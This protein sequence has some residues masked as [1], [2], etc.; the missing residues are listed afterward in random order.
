MRDAALAEKKDPPT[1]NR[2]LKL[3]HS[4]ERQSSV[5][6]RIVTLFPVM[7]WGTAV[8]DASHE[9]SI[10]DSCK[11]YRLPSRLDNGSLRR[12]FRMYVIVD[13]TTNALSV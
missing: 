13:A 7:E 5:G 3:L 2:T 11:N 8:Q 12:A 4:Q 1:R 10:V 6:T 9:I